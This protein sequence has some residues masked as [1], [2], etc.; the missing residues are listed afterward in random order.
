MDI[1]VNE[2]R[3]RERNDRSTWWQNPADYAPTNVEYTCDPRLEVP[4]AVDCMN[5]EFQIDGRKNLQAGPEKPFF[6]NSRMLCDLFQMIIK[7]SQVFFFF[8]KTVQ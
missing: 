2:R 6:V 5:A 4:K 3:M 8:M 7:T 1:H